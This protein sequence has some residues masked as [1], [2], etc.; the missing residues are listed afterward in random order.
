MYI[1][2]STPEETVAGWQS[3]RNTESQDQCRPRACENDDDRT[4][5]CVPDPTNQHRALPS[6]L[7]ACDLP[8]PPC[9]F[10]RCPRSRVVVNSLKS[11][12]SW[13]GWSAS[14]T[15]QNPSLRFP[16]HNKLSLTFFSLLFRPPSLPYPPSL[17]APYIPANLSHLPLISITNMSKV[18]KAE[19]VA[20][21][22]KPDDLYI[23]VDQDVYDL[24]QFQDEHPGGKKSA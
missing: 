14:F 16:R 19:E 12:R 24:T 5:A 17:C 23:I 6:D 13:L 18:F 15:C 3:C 4:E 11:R 10:E 7:R 1:C 9:G 8:S 2:S 20:A 22:K 21:H